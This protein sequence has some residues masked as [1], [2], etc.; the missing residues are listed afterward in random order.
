MK[1]TRI[2]II[3]LFCLCCIISGCSNRKEDVVELTM[4]HGW[5]STEADHIIMRQIYE[6]FEKEH[7][8]IH[9]NLVSMPSSADVINKVGDLLTVGEIPDIVFTGG[10]GRDSYF[11]EAAK[12]IIDK[13]KASIGMLQRYLK[14]GFNRA[15]RIMDQLEE[16]GI[17]GPEEGTKPRKVLMTPS[18]FETYLE[19]NY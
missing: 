18:E 4:I 14:V 16:A 3:F 15:A 1:K 11:M 8:N 6:D 17:V 10:D 13:E 2:R 12:I 19:E 7:P 9:L 5:G